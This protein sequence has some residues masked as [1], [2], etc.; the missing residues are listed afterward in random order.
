MTFGVSSSATASGMARMRVQTESRSRAR[1]RKPWTP[2]STRAVTATV[3]PERRPRGTGLGRGPGIRAARLQQERGEGFETPIGGPVDHGAPAALLLDQPA[4]GEKPE[5]MG[6]GGRRD[7]GA[8]LDL[9]DGEPLVSGAHEQAQHREPGLGAAR[10]EPL[11]RLFECDGGLG[12][13]VGVL[14]EFHI[15]SFIVILEKV[16][17]ASGRGTWE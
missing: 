1:M 14:F 9:A 4:G 8:L 6:Q 15:T 5:V 12:K 10:S 17:G 11:R 3:A 2:R 7:G 16:K 13:P